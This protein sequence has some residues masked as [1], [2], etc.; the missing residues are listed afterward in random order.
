[1]ATRRDYTADKV[2][3]A[4]RVL[5]ELAAI[6]GEYREYIVL[7]GGWIPEFLMPSAAEPYVG[8]MD[9]DL[10]L[11]HVNLNEA[12]YRTIRKL[13]SDNGYRQGDQRFKF[14]RE[15]TIN[16]IVQTVEI[17]FL[18]GE[19]GGTGKGHRHQRIQDVMARKARGCEL[20]FVAN[21]EIFLEGPLPN[22]ALARKGL[23]IADIVSFIAMKGF[24]MD[25]RLKEK[26]AW[27]IY[28]CLKYYPGGL[29]KL[30]A[31]FQPYMSNKL[32]VEGLKRVAEGFK[33]IDHIGP[34]SAADFDNMHESDER[35]LRKRDA[36]ERV[37]YLLSKLGL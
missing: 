9:V 12:G 10:A 19:Y 23:K 24:A 5:L 6:L 3:A 27:D 1:M 11:D 28:Y 14:L 32:L 26:D 35:Q 36:F 34:N 16:G 2:E 18:A 25:G 20:A 4:R 30:A 8:S 15:V 31:A 33:T 22:G 17:D 13:L 29:D 37:H 7:V 21:Y